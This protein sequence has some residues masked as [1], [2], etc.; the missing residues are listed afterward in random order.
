MRGNVEAFLLAREHGVRELVLHQLPQNV[1]QRGAADL[2]ILGQRSRE[3]HD[4][5]IQKRRPHL[6]RVRHAHAVALVQDVV[7]QVA[8]LVEPQVAVELARLRRPAGGSHSNSRWIGAWSS[9]AHS[10][11]FSD[12]LN[13]PF[14]K[15]WASSGAEQRARQEP[16]QL[17]LEADLLVGR[18]PPAR[19]RRAPPAATPRAPAAA[20]RPGRSA[21]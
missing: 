5:V 3:L 6:E 12:T 2:Q 17:V 13:A 7:G 14:Q 16:L 1:L 8:E 4:A 18:R 19:A 9:K 20:A 11:R 15:T 10:S 21:M